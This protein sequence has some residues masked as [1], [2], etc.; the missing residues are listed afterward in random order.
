[1]S[2]EWG[3]H[4]C[5]RFCLK[6]LSAVMA[7]RAS[8][9]AR[10]AKPPGNASGCAMERIRAMWNGSGYGQGREGARAWETSRVLRIQGMAHALS[11]K[12]RREVP[13]DAHARGAR[14]ASAKSQKP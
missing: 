12:T 8:G 6:S 3:D 11:E 9:R 2:F 7:T 13:W 4:R 14:A 10:D 1:M 5:D